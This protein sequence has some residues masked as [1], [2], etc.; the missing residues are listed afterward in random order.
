VNPW[1]THSRFV[2]S[3]HLL[4]DEDY[5]L[6]LRDWL[7]SDGGQR[8]L[9]L[10]E[11]HNAAPA[12]GAKDAIDSQFTKSVRD[13]VKQFEH[14]LFLSA[15]PHSGHSNSFSALIEMLDDQ[16]FCRG[17][18]VESAKQLE[19]ARDHGRCSRPDSPA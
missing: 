10:D 6:P 2:V 9:I 12:S 13:L 4:R 18:P 7:T 11:A 17:V 8:M 1:T 14:K 19:H 15:T 3:H 16:R 5:A